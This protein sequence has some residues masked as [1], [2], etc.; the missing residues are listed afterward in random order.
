VG[1]IDL[2]H[3]ELLSQLRIH[4]QLLFLKSWN[5]PLSQ[6][7]CHYLQQHRHTLD[8]SVSQFYHARHASSISLVLEY[9]SHTFLPS[10][11]IVQISLLVSFLLFKFFYLFFEVVSGSN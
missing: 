6:I 3:I 11:Y 5:Y 8:F 4:R 9:G 1:V 7:N 2:H 10:L